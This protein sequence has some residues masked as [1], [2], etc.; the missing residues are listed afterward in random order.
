MEQSYF[1]NTVYDLRINVTK[2]EYFWED[3]IYA[4]VVIDSGD[5]RIL[6]D[7]IITIWGTCEGLYTYESV[8]G[9]SVSL[10][11]IKVEYYAIQQ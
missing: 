11:K 4:T 8:L 10:P 6:E 9:S 1:G 7:D 2:G 5:D 3:T